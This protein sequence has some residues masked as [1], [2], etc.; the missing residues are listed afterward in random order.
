MEKGKQKGKADHE[1]K[2]KWYWGGGGRKERKIHRRSEN[3]FIGKI[4]V[5]VRI[6]N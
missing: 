4:S 5:E 6:G 3:N 1:G 2:G